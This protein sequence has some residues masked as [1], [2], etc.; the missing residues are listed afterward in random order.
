MI[1]LAACSCRGAARPKS[2]GHEF[3]SSHPKCQINSFPTVYDMLYIWHVIYRWK[4]Q[5]PSFPLSRGTRSCIRVYGSGAHV[6]CLRR[7]L[8]HFSPGVHWAFYSRH[9]NSP[10]HKRKK[11]KIWSVLKRKSLKLC[12]L[13]HIWLLTRYHL[14]TI[15]L[16]HW[17]THILTSLVYHKQLS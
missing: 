11:I 16:S 14:N 3:W 10:F 15:T 5:K 6:M 12:D 1:G 7:A 2:G 9:C 17:L 4:A 13:A 8:S